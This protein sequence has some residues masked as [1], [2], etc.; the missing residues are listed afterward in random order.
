MAQTDPGASSRPS[1]GAMV[2]NWRTYDA[3]FRTKLRMTLSN[4]WTKVRKRQNCCGNP[5][6]P[7]C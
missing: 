2:S 6:Q 5:G 7:G 1:F 4:N 3:P